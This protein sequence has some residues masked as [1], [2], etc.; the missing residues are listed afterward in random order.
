MIKPVVTEKSMEA[1]AKN[2]YTFKVDR[3]AAK[4]Q[5]KKAVEDKFKV[6]VIKVRTINVKKKKKRKKA[7]VKIKEGQKIEGFGGEK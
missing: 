2:C 1:T 6:N 4:N 3:K 7:I 5:I